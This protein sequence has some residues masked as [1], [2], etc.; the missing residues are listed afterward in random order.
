[1]LQLKI[2]VLSIL[3]IYSTLLGQGVGNPAPN[4]TY[5]TLDHGQL[6]L[7]DYDGKI[8]YSFFYAWW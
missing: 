1:M 6:S 3:T 4:F 7:S 8:I 5:N 2:I